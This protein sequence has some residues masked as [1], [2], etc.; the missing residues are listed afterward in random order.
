MKPFRFALIAATMLAAGS[1]AHADPSHADPKAKKVN[2]DSPG[3]IA[4][5]ATGKSEPAPLDNAN[6]PPPG[7]ATMGGGPNRTRRVPSIPTRRARNS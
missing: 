7:G 2:G 3:D 5:L 4:P 6:F 1:A